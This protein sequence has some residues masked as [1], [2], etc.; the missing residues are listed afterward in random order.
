[1]W[2]GT[3]GMTGRR[4]FRSV[5][6]RVILLFIIAIVFSYAG[7][8]VI[9]NQGIE[10]IQEEMTVVER[11]RTEYLTNSLEYNIQNILTME[12]GELA[13]RDFMKFSYPDFFTDNYSRYETQQ[14]I[15]ERLSLI[16]LCCD[17][18]DDASVYFPMSGEFFSTISGIA[19]IEREK[20]ELAAI[21]H[22][23]FETENGTA[24]VSAVYPFRGAGEKP[25]NFI[26]SARISREKLSQHIL[27]LTGEAPG[28]FALVMH[29]TGWYATD[30]RELDEKTLADLKSSTNE[31][32]VGTEECR[33]NGGSFLV[34]WNSLDSFG[35]K[36]VVCNDMTEK[37]ESIFEMLKSLMFFSIVCLLLL[38]LFVFQIKRTLHQPM[39]LLV[40]AFEKMRN[41]DFKYRISDSAS[42]E[43]D[44]LYESYNKMAERIDELVSLV[45]KE[46]ILAMESEYRYLQA[47]INP[48]FL[49]NCFFLLKGQIELGDTDT[50]A[51]MCQ[52][53]GN[54]FQFITK[55]NDRI[56]VLEKEY[57]HAITYSEIQML[58]FGNRLN[59]E[60]EPLAEAIRKVPVPR[61]VIQPLVENAFEHGVRSMRDG[62]IR[63]WAE[64][65]GEDLIITVE[66]N[67]KLTDEELQ[68]MRK[69][70]ETG[71]F[72]KENTALANISQRLRI[73]CGE[74][75][76]LR[77]S[78]SELGGL[79]IQICLLGFRKGENLCIDF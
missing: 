38:I 37:R 59:I 35:L 78:R 46:K 9:V 22:S 7:E 5:Y 6:S 56:I 4:R 79:K 10:K 63:L 43:F 42:N 49:Y 47:Q 40:S 71:V 39:T 33:L 1:M 77:V 15:Q 75:G 66:N 16:V 73:I 52:K 54:Y 29:E 69:W 12:M 72:P 3:D 23:G 68:E 14:K 2:K 62:K 21:E 74:N 26:L 20:A 11:N 32:S 64:G 18:V 27:E 24:R 31:S 8:I 76:G 41:E 65:G 30:G 44:Y 50:A 28:S 13:N 53:L 48:H 58:R 51:Q 55:S 36:T 34:T 60:C 25:F 70:I 19:D 57:Q 61:M 67:G 45:Y 17:L